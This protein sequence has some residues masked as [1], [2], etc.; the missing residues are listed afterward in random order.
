MNTYTV[1]D[2][3]EV[4][5]QFKKSV[6]EKHGVNIPEDD[7]FC[8]EVEL[9]AALVE[10]LQQQNF[11]LANTLKTR[12][13]EVAQMWVSKEEKVWEN[14]QERCNTLLDNFSK[15][16]RE[17][18]HKAMIEAIN[19]AEN[20]RENKEIQAL[21]AHIETQNSKLHSLMK[22]IIGLGVINLIGLVAITRFLL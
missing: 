10:N 16:S 3:A 1:L 4:L 17:L 13:T 5:A 2:P 22:I 12:I 21:K 6:F 7:P 8:L 14:Y 19:D 18:Y 20:K 9:M 15:N 11:Q